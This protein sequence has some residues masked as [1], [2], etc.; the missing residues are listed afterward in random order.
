MAYLQQ[1]PCRWF[2][3]MWATCTPSSLTPLI[4]CRHRSSSL[5]R[6]LVALAL[7]ASL[8]IRCDVLAL[9]P[10][11]LVSS[12][13]THAWTSGGLAGAITENKYA[14]GGERFLRDAE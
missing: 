4:C 1:F 11:A 7:G 3:P 9:R 10:D 8:T 14:R 13:Y 2:L 5:I 6:G 12:A